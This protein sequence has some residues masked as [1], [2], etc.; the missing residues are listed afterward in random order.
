VL[1]W[2]KT[3]PSLERFQDSSKTG[4]GINFLPSFLRLFLLPFLPPFLAHFFEYA[5]QKSFAR[6]FLFVGGGSVKVFLRTVCCCQKLLY[7]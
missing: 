1:G 7:I 4:L 2:N 5:V 3:R 6:F